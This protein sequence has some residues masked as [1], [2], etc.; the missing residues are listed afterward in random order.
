MTSSLS[1]KSSDMLC[2]YL[3]GVVLAK[4]FSFQNGTTEE[5]TSEEEEEE[6]EEVDEE[7]EEDE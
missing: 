7:E 6:V 5:V 2:A 1:L 4:F 3:F